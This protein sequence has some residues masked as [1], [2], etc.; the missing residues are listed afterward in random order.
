MVYLR[1]FSILIIFAPSL[2]RG[3]AR[4]AAPVE[5]SGLGVTDVSPGSRTGTGGRARH[6]TVGD[7]I[8][9]VDA[10]RLCDA[11]VEVAV[12]ESLPRLGLCVDL[13]QGELR[14][15]R[16]PVLLPQPPPDAPGNAL[17]EGEPPRASPVRIPLILSKHVVGLP[18]RPD[19]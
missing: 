8:S 18:Q 3:Q 2:A 12:V 1:N 13:L 10:P 15:L 16:E 4:D 19:R 11:E 9:I 6:R 14:R 5:E 17:R 7:P